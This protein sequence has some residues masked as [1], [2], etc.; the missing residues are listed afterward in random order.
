MKWDGGFNPKAASVTNAQN[1]LIPMGVTSENVAAKWHIS[2][3]TQDAF[4]AESHRRAAEA[5]RNGKFKSQ[6]VPVVTKIIDKETT[7]GT[8]VVVSADDGIRE[9]VTVEH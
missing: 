6:I 8:E 9:G 3:E 1:C 5:R 7:E 4:A 2:R